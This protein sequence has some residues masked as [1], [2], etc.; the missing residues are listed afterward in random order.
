MGPKP[1]TTKPAPGH[2]IFPYFLRDLGIDRPNPAWAAN[3]ISTPIGR[4]SLNLVAIRVPMAV[5][6]DGI[7]G[8]PAG[9]AVDMTLRLDDAVASPP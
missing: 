1:K 9:D 3:I 5:W 4:V 6:R 7:I 2:K 8:V